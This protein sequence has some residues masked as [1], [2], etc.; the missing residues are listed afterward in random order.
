MTPSANPPA[1]SEGTNCWSFEIAAGNWFGM[2]VFLPNFRNMKNYSDGYLHFDIRTTEGDTTPLQVGIQ[3]CVAGQLAGD[4]ANFWLPLGVDQTSEFGFARDGQWHSLKIPLNRFANVDFRTVNQL[5]QISSVVNPTA[6]LNLSIDNVWWE[7][8]ST[9]VTPQNGDFG[10]F[11]ETPSHMTA[12]SF[13]LATQGNFFVWANTMVPTTKHP[14]EGTND[15]S[16]A[17]AGVGWTGMAFTPNAKYNL[18]AFSYPG[19]NLEFAMKT[20]SA[21][22]F[23]VGMKSGNLDGVGQKWLTFPGP[24]GDPYGFVRDGQWHVVDIPMSNFAPEVDLSA[25]S[26][27]FEILSQSAALSNIEVDDVHFT[28]GGAASPPN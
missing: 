9:R 16:L 11:T 19:C 21:T 20:T 12:G 28:N 24:G 4:S 23:M 27:F 1:P 17:S 25:V 13:A 5:F 18:S 8:S 15:I 10:V 22:P 3:S 14:Y 2:G 26:Q 7:P 6:P